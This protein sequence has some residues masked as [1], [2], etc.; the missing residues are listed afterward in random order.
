ML[1]A[2]VHGFWGGPVDW[3]PVLRVL[4]L[5]Q[6]VW[7]PDLYEPG[8]L[9]PHHTL[10]EWTTHFIEEIADRA[11]GQ[12]VQAVGYSMG[13]RLLTS[14]L[15]R[16][17]QLF[18]R[19]LVMS[20][21]ALPW[22]G[23]GQERESWELDWR[24]RFLHEPWEVLEQD[25]SSQDVFC[26]SAKPQRRQS[27]ILREMLGQSLVNWSPTRHGYNLEDVKSLPRTVDWVFGALDQKY[28][29]VAKDLAKLP[30]QGQITVIEN[31]GHRLTHDASQWIADWVGRQ[32]LSPTSG[33]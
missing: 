7:T 2:L 21:Q 9:G 22:D 6:E 26:G 25:W 30:V 10:A 31:A 4:P 29:K 27:A 14:A 11:K 12:P 33:G 28:V 1:T 15:V 13:G 8:P 17:P 3:N 16:R 5:G 18:H 23:R 24:R 20:A 32:P 19:A